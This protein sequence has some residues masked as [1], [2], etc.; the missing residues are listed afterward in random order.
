LPGRELQLRYSAP[1]GPDASRLEATP[2]TWL[3][4]YEATILVGDLT[5][6]LI[7]IEAA[8]QTPVDYSDLGD[9]D[10]ILFWV[11][12]IGVVFAAVV[13]AIWISLGMARRRRSSEA[14]RM[15]GSGPTI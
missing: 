7:L 9:D 14:P 12:R 8:E 11:T 13:L 1:L 3:T 5:E 10:G 6:D 15:P 2:D 4:R